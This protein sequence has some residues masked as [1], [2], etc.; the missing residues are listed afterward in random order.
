[1]KTILVIIPPHHICQRLATG[2]DRDGVV[3]VSFMT[4]ALTAMATRGECRQRHQRHEA[5][6]Q[7]SNQSDEW[8]Q[9]ARSGTRSSP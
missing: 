6:E 7:N 5:A 3:D 8:C 9:H 4:S 2:P 1:M